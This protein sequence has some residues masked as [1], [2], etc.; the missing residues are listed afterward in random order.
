MRRGSGDRRAVGST[1]GRPPAD[2]VWY[3][4]AVGVCNAA[5]AVAR[6]F[7]VGRSARQRGVPAEPVGNSDFPIWKG[8]CARARGSLPTRGGKARTA[9]AADIELRH[10]RADKLHRDPSGLQIIIESRID[11][12][13]FGRP[14]VAVG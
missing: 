13:A 9:G 5:K 12:T 1:R 3:T 2:L 14:R 11:V 4:A 7:A 6:G 10:R 8:R